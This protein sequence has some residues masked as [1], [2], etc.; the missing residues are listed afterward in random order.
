MSST[1]S[2]TCA[3]PTDCE[4]LERLQPCNCVVYGVE[5]PGM[6]GVGRLLVIARV[7]FHDVALWLLLVVLFL[8]VLLAVRVIR[9]DRY[10]LSYGRAAKPLC[11]RHF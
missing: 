11:W 10:R 4:V 8:V 7:G 6:C 1:A 5:T 3:F 9:L 2:A